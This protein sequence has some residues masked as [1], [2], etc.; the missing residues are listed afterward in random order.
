MTNRGIKR[1]NIAKLDV[2]EFLRNFFE[3]EIPLILTHV[4]EDLGS[5]VNE[6]TKLLAAILKDN[7]V[8]TNKTWFQTE[9]DFFRQ[10]IET[11]K[12][13]SAAL[14]SFRS[15]KR[16]QNLRIWVNAQGH[17]TPFH[18]DVNGLFVFNYQVFGKKRWQIV[19]PDGEL[20]KHAFT[21]IAVKKYNQT[22][23]PELG[24]AVVEF[25]L[26][27]GEMLFLP[28][29]WYHRVIALEKIN[30]NVNWVGT[31]KES[32]PNRLAMR[33]SEIM[34]ALFFV[35]H[36]YPIRKAVDLLVGSKEDNYFAN[37]AGNGGIDLVK[38][39]LSGVSKRRAF[40]RV[41]RELAALPRLAWEW[42]T[43]RSYQADPAKVLRE[44]HFLEEMENL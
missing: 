32:K 2:S 20:E 7:R 30:L 23:P 40:L 17:E 16:I 37:Y 26:N 5:T 15:F 41:C 9:S 12:L 19:S 4:T 6:V 35:S 28:P 13:V 44:I 39:R 1:L 27:E 42:N 18:A 36:L 22:L 8:K 24:S 31:K 38:S 11:P 29:Y 3:P 43:I 21:Q 14:E 25:D 10:K 34:K 33:E